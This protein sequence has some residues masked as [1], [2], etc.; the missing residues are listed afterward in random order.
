MLD[1]GSQGDGGAGEIAAA[2]ERINQA[3]LAAQA[4]QL[5]SQQDA[6]T[7]ATAAQTASDKAASDQRD[8]D[9]QKSRDEQAAQ[10]KANQATGNPVSASDAASTEKQMA[11]SQQTANTAALPG[12]NS[13][14]NKLQQAQ[15][16][17]GGFAG[18]SNSLTSGF[19]VQ[20]PGGRRYV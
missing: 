7:A 8:A 13:L 2:N 19:N 11:I 6:T 1:S 16:K 4:A 17:N 20:N 14:A 18:Q 15:Q 5:K 12:F 9:L 3:N 10:Q